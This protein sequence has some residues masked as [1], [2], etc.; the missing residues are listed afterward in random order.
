LVQITDDPHFIVDKIFDFYE[1]R[2]FAPTESERAQMMQ[3]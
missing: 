2:G 1:K 3:L